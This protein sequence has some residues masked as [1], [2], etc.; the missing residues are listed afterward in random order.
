MP[1]LFFL[2]AFVAATIGCSSEPPKAVPRSPTSASLRADG[3]SLAADSAR[4]F[5]QD[6]YDWYV[7]LANHSANPYD[8]L[9]AKRRDFL[10][11]VLY[12]AFRADIEG[13]RADTIAEVASVTASYDPFL[14]SQDPCERYE[15]RRAKPIATGFAV[16]I[17]GLC[18]N[19]PPTGSVVA[20]IA[21]GPH[22]WQ[23]VNFRDPSMPSY[24]LLT[25]FKEQR[26]LPP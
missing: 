12:A 9:L 22:G 5:A 6:F 15:A 14:N 13:Q 19:S 17:Y 23:F 3:L 4:R 24:D 2:V 1:R 26:E 25:E 10:A 7:P 21:R 20:E 18:S 11:P 8:S 16:E